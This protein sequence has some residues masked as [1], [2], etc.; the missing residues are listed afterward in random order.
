MKFERIFT[1]TSTL[2]DIWSPHADIPMETRK[3]IC[4]G[5][6]YSIEVPTFWSQIAT[7]ILVSKYVRKAGVPQDVV[8]VEEEKVPE[9]LWR[10]I[11]KPGTSL[12]CE[13]DFSY[14]AHRLTG[15]W[16]Y[17]GWKKGYFS[18]E[19]DA[20]AFYS[21]TM[22]MLAMQMAAPASPQWFNTG[23]WWAYGI[24]GEDCGRWGF[25]SSKDGTSADDYSVFR[26]M[27]SFKKPPL[28][29]CFIQ[30]VEDSLL[31]EQGIMDLMVREV[32]V[33][34]G[35]G[36]SGSNF[37]KLRGKGEPLSGG[38]FSSGLISFLKAIDTNAGSIRSGGTLRRSAK[39]VK[40][41]LD[42]PDIW[43]FIE[44]KT[45]EEEKVAAL[46]IGAKI[47]KKHIERLFECWWKWT[48]IEGIKI[49]PLE[50][51]DFQQ[52]VA[53]AKE[54]GVPESVLLR[55]QL[56]CAQGIRELPLQEFTT[57]FEGEA[58]L[59]VS[60]QNANNSVGIPFDFFDLLDKGAE[61]PLYWRTELVK[62]EKENRDPVPCAK[63]DCKKLWDHI[64]F[65]AWSCADPG[66]H[67]D[68]TINDWNPTIKDG[69]IR[70]SN[71][72][73]VGE[74][75]IDT[76]DG[77][78][79]IEDLC[80][81]FEEDP[82]L[83]REQVYS[84]WK[85]GSV[86]RPIKRVW[87]TGTTARLVEVQTDSGIK[88]RCTPEHRFLLSA[89]FH[90]DYVEAQ[91]LLPGTQLKC[92][93]SGEDSVQSITPIK[94]DQ[95]VPVYDIEVDGVH[96]F[97]VTD[98][99][100]PFRPSIVVHNCSE[101]LF[102]DDTGC[103]LASLNLVSFYD[104][105]NEK[106]KIREFVHAVEIWTTIL[107]ISVELAG[108]PSKEIAEGSAKYRTLGLGYSNLGSLL[109]T[110]GLPYDSDEGRSIAACLACLLTSTAYTQSSR[111]AKELGT[112][113]RYEE[114]KE[115]CL[116]VICNHAHAF[117]GISCDRV[118]VQP[119]TFPDIS[120]EPELNRVAHQA[121]IHMI[122]MVSKNGLRNAQVTLLQPAGTTGLLMDNQTCGIEPDFALVK[123]KKLVGGGSF[124]MVNQSVPAALQKLGY[125]QSQIDDIVKHVSGHGGLNGC[126]HL[127]WLDLNLEIPSEEIPVLVQKFKTV[128]DIRDAIPPAKVKALTLTDQQWKEV[129]DYV[130]G[131]MT[132]EGT[133]HLLEED[134]PVFD[135]AN[136]CGSQGKRFISAEGHLKMMAAVQPLL[137]GGISKTVN[138]PHDASI[139][140]VSKVYRMAHDLGLKCIAIYRDQSKLSQILTVDQREDTVEEKDVEK[141][142]IQEELPLDFIS[143]EE[144]E[145]IVQMKEKQNEEPTK[146]RRCLPDRRSGYTQ[147]FR[148]GGSKIYLRTGEYPDGTLGEI[149]LDMHKEGAA[150]RSMTNLFAIAVSLGLQHGVPLEEFVDAFTFVK[151]E[152]NGP[153]SG[154]S[155]IKFAHSTIDAIFRDL[156]IHYLG[157]KD[158]E[159]P[160]MARENAHPDEFNG[161]FANVEIN[162][163]SLANEISKRVQRATDDLRE[164]YDLSTLKK[165]PQEI[166]ERFRI[167]REA[168]QKGYEGDPCPDCGMMTL[169]RSGTCK[170]C[171]T[172]GFSSGC[173]G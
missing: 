26:V 140:D 82:G 84:W 145:S 121:S 49:N 57:D 6:E 39:M 169:V 21:E 173:S 24:E 27:D 113:P 151:F 94:L 104:P 91:N 110:M 114:N 90:G 28:D 76:V 97:G 125:T 69:L 98:N 75:L 34:K 43:Q 63:L 155:G 79:P 15:H 163:D 65:N 68:T 105:L 126:P 115:D 152:P 40:N 144:P 23:I 70:S 35:G 59:T 42:H 156:A 47:Q 1:P 93:L 111:L 146:K 168:R 30:N 72:C 8:L 18:S 133:P 96:N 170:R 77:R 102:L 19:E 48:D 17:E 95:P 20:W 122:D 142:Q 92:L 101:Y 143:Y 85:N 31:G 62:A 149:W 171:G 5:K 41:P 60:G 80:H 55:V 112:F 86:F 136:R 13:N 66:L 67:F 12:G 159:N 10:G 148:V 44:W 37:S 138:M 51:L 166:S 61:W 100:D 167:A 50:C 141:E 74:T 58:Y 129:N 73:F 54:D 83:F 123:W 71:P 64:V 33:Y 87:M 124:K 119:S 108:Y 172:C 106:W 53:R 107:D 131:Q 132:I 134:L 120:V 153:V 165:V 118:H 52:I 2:G 16:T 127:H 9:W 150:F 154:H 157:R 164:G 14:I 137:S 46:V 109:M 36:G 130:Y 162:E 103:N 116:R 32:T 78:I 3:S 22:A 99:K 117:V 135:C 38:G 45:K 89:G 158:L 147:K 128:M 161:L 56:L 29:A 88:V 25:H 139:E 4:Q 81:D 160:G 11:P 7:D